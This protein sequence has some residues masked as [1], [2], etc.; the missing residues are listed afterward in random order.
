MIV[1]VTLLITIRYTSIKRVIYY[2][3]FVDAIILT[4]V[5]LK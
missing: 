3:A 2:S 1:Y 4:Y 5:F